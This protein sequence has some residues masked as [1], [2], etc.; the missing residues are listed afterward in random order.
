MACPQKLLSRYER[1]GF[2]PTS[3]FFVGSS[4][5]VDVVYAKLVISQILPQSVPWRQSP[6]ISSSLGRAPIALRSPI[7]STTA[8]NPGVS[9]ITGR[10]PRTLFWIPLVLSEPLNKSICCHR[11]ARILS[12][13]SS[14][15]HS[16]RCGWRVSLSA[17]EP[18]ANR[19]TY[20]RKI[21]IWGSTI[22]F[23][24]TALFLTYR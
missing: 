16:R 11:S 23:W 14:A 18:S 6:G 17:A 20:S 22:W 5:I 2:G 13:R 1:S 7:S 19:S 3:I 4:T 9:S 12:E 10:A 15:V 24:R 21:S 8:F